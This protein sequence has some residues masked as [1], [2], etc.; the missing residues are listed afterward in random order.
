MS[1]PPC[2]VGRLRLTCERL[3]GVDEH[4]CRP[5][6]QALVNERSLAQ[7]SQRLYARRTAAHP[8]PHRGVR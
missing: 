3:S 2:G 1:S 7:T 5:P 4:T 8:A 6:W